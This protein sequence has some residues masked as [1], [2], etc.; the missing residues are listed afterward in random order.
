[1]RFFRGN[2]SSVSPEAA[3]MRHNQRSVIVDGIGV[4]IVTGIATFLAVFLARLGAS[5]L[6]VGLLT[7]LPAFTGLLLAIPVGRI[8]ERQRDLVPWYS[9]ARIGVQASYALTGLLPFL[10]PIQYVPIAVIVIWAIATIP[11][12]IVNITFTVVMGAVAGPQRRQQLMSWRWSTLGAASALSVAGAGWLLEQ[13]IFPTNY[14]VVFIFSFIGGMLSFFFSSRITMPP[15][16]VTHTPHKPGLRTLVT[17]S[18]AMFRDVPAFGRF[19]LASFV[20]NCGIW[21]AMPLFPLYWVRVVQASDFWIGI[22]N[23]VN[24]GVL[25]VA[26]FLWARVTSTRGN[27]PVLFASTIALAL[28]PLLTG[29]T[30]SIP[31]IIV[32][33]GL[34]GL[35]GA[36]KDLVFFDIGLSTMPKDR[37][38]SFVAVQQLTGYI[39]T[40]VMPLIGTWMAQNLDYHLA[41]YVAAA[42]RLS[43]VALLYLLKVGQTEPPSA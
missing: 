3:Q 19:V 17:E 31:L 22:I 27:R 10:I 5:P 36:G 40:L 14:Q 21:M 38:P 41:L 42:L 12:T 32:F 33:A 26:Y 18:V 20:F 2:D 37:V 24:N 16:E 35:I 30:V 28:Y 7:S 9:R 8:L 23:T 11:Q 25:L 39:A 13:F 1:M 34:V 15:N 4:G 6:L 29:L 43:G